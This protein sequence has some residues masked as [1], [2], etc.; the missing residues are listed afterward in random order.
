GGAGRRRRSILLFQ[1]AVRALEI[2]EPLPR[3]DPD[4]E[5]SFSLARRI[6]ID[7]AWK[8]ALL[9]LRDE[10]RRLERLD[11]IFRRALERDAEEGR[12]GPDDRSGAGPGPAGG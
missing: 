5:L 12:R 9:E 10:A 3:L 11:V 7:A 6:R 2:D 8:Q 4:R 1:A